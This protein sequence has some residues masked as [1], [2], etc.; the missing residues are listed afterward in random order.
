VTTGT[1]CSFGINKSRACWWGD[2][3]SELKADPML[4]TEYDYL[5]GPVLLR[6]SQYLIPSEARAYQRALAK[7]KV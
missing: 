6:V 1:I 2:R 4:G 3:H 5:N 7:I